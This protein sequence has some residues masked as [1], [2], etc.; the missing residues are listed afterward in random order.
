MLD[1]TCLGTP[2]VSF[3]PFYFG[4]SSLELNMRKTGTLIIA[5]LLGGVDV[6]PNYQGLYAGEGI[7]EILCHD[8]SPN[9]LHRI[10]K[11]RS[12]LNVFV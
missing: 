8:T 5:G 4:V 9:L 2:V 1:L 3:S 11:S 10:F 6:P 12:L 7:L